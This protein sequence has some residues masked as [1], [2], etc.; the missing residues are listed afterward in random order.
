MDY[1]PV[2]EV[3]AL[4]RRKH[5]GHKGT[6]GTVLVLAGSRGMGG[7]AVLCGRAALR[8]GAGLV[9]VACPADTQPIVA[10][11]YPA[12]TTLAVRQHADGTFGDGTAEEVIELA[13]AADAL[14]LGP[15]LGR[16]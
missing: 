5:D 7:A 1:I 13:R 4:P 14:A 16:E 10:G 8:A 11:A 12:Y 3:P 2:C 6:Y 9:R 15:G